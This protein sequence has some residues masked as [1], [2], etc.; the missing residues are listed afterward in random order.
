[1][2]G[3]ERA[4]YFFQRLSLTATHGT[5]LQ[6]SFKNDN[7]LVFQF[8]FNA[9]YFGQHFNHARVDRRSAFVRFDRPHRLPELGRF[10]PDLAAQVGGTFMAN[11]DYTASSFVSL[12]MENCHFEHDTVMRR[13]AFA[14]QAQASFCFILDLYEYQVVRLDERLRITMAERLKRINAVRGPRPDR[15]G[16][17]RQPFG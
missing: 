3:I 11:A 15:S 9:D 5:H 14:E 7:L 8:R 13:L 17:G 16:V 10:Y 2:P 4:N 6:K 1:M 12:S